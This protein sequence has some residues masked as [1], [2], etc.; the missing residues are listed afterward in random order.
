MNY[1]TMQQSRE[2]SNVCLQMRGCW[3]ILNQRCWEVAFLRIYSF[4]LFFSHNGLP[5]NFLH[6]PVETV[7]SSFP[8]LLRK[9]NQ[10]R[11][12]T[13]TSPKQ[14]M[15]S[16]FTTASGRESAAP[17][18]ASLERARSLL[19]DEPE[20]SPE[21]SEAMSPGLYGEGWRL[22][23]Q[24][25]SPSPFARVHTHPLYALL[26]AGASGEDR[27]GVAAPIQLPARSFSSG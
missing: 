16:S 25:S 23:P 18:T 4:L 20:V 24:V 14:S 10:K 2:F 22:L 19:F 7:K 26:G 8:R 15:T 9:Q 21:P 12:S 6:I 11:G 5:R 13:E 3:S 1:T 27:H 17:S